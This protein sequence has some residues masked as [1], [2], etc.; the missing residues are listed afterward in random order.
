MNTADSESSEPED[1]TA[2]PQIDEVWCVKWDSLHTEIA[3]R[4]WWADDLIH[5][6]PTEGDA[7]HYAEKLRAACQLLGDTGRGFTVTKQVVQ[8]NA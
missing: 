8:I 4:H 2:A 3:D 1:E 6:F 7:S 5:V